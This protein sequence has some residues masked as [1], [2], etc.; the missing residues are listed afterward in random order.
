MKKKDTIQ[1]NTPN[2]RERYTTLNQTTVVLSV[3][4]RNTKSGFTRTH[5]DHRHISM[6]YITS[7]GS[8]G[9]QTRTIGMLMRL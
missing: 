9:M 6:M 2:R 1:R 5:M 3:H 8:V 7:T 4:A